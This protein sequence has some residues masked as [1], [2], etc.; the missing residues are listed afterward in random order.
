MALD[1]LQL[2]QYEVVVP[3]DL[4]RILFVL[5]RGGTGAVQLDVL[6]NLPL[7]MLEFKSG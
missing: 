5:G 3:L 2:K 6:L 1:V 4:L 7:F